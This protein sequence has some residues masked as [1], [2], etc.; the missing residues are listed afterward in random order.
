MVAMESILQEQDFQIS[1]CASDECAVEIGQLFG[2]SI[3]MAGS[4]GKVGSTYSIVLRTINVETGQVASSLTSRYRGE[5]DGL[6]DRMEDIAKEWV[7]DYQRSTGALPAVTGTIS[8][9]SLPANSTV[10]RW[11]TGGPDT[12]P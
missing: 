7:A 5:I 3:M 8:V 2:V 4:I 12:A 1:G 9:Q 11:L 10:S 6:L